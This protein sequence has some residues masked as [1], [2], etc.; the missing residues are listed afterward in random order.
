[1]AWKRILV[2]C[3]NWVGDVVMATPALRALRTSFPEA[4]ITGLV[5]PY[6]SLILEGAPWFDRLWRYDRRRN[7]LRE[8]IRAV[9]GIRR[10]DFDLAVVFP[11]SF[12]TALLAR[13]G[14]V[15]ERVGYVR[16]R[17]GLLLTRSLP[18]PGEGPGEE[19]AFQPVYM[20]DYYLDLV[21]AAGA[22]P[23]GRHLEIFLPP[24]TE[25]KAAALLERLGQG[26]GGRWIGLNPGA[27]F[28]SSKCWLPERF[29]EAGDRLA[30]RHGA[31]CII[32]AGPGEEEVQGR[33]ASLMHS[34]PATPSPGEVP[35]DVLKG[36]VK[37]LDLLVT[38]DTGPRHFAHAFN[39]PAVVLMGPTD[40]RY[41]QCGLE[42]AKVLRV[43]V[44]CGP[45]HLKVCPT[46]H[47][48]MTALT[49]DLVVEAAAE[50][51][52]EG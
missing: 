17:R 2:I 22:E 34:S 30:E 3:P 49:A 36:V 10:E 33:I 8:A 18:R 44:D 46:D 43:E 11:N 38:N 45:C 7:S 1:M 51:L 4:K 47:R 32:L 16:D 21:A 12:S 5:R 25:A 39:V 50:L 13:L 27:A 19:G 20:V 31:R 42:R 29:A 9:R 28:G 14:G 15:G 41:T 6:V 48:C 52:G 35:L 26:P 40:P 24:E 37:G 23:S